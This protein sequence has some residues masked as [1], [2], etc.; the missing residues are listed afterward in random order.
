MVNG[1]RLISL[2]PCSS[3]TINP[4]TAPAQPETSPLT[5]PTLQLPWGGGAANAGIA[6][7]TIIAAI[8]NATTTNIMMRLIKHYLSFVQPSMGCF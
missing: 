7:A 2:H 1:P 8:T 4:P 5:P 6:M 3:V